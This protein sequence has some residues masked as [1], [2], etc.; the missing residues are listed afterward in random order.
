VHVLPGEI[1][2]E[3][4]IAVVFPE[5]E[6]VPPQVRAF[7]DALSAWLPGKFEAAAAARDDS[8]ERATTN[9]A[10]RAKP[11]PRPAGTKAKAA[12][13]TKPK[14]TRAPAKKTSR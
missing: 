13:A 12:R 14:K 6:L 7:I 5:R 3:S 9:T 8:P 2:I 1:T 4:R 11:S 10:S